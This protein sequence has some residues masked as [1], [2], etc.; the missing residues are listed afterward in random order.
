ME[1][2][3]DQSDQEDLRLLLGELR[4]IAA[5]S[6]EQT[7]G[8]KCRL[9]GSRGRYFVSVRTSEGGSFWDYAGGKRDILASFRARLARMA[10][11][12]QSF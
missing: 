8:W 9:S 2:V 7:A 3:L 1:G 6:K 5:E 4:A 12:R 10:E 11:L